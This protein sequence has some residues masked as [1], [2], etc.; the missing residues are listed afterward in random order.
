MHRCGKRKILTEHNWNGQHK[1]SFS[2]FPNKTNSFTCNVSLL[3]IALYHSVL[4][5]NACRAA[6]V[7]CIQSKYAAGGAR[8]VGWAALFVEGEVLRRPFRVCS[9]LS[10]SLLTPGGAPSKLLSYSSRSIQPFF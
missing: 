4:P 5:G 10:T 3:C 8:L 7:I 6:I 1:L 9:I 2:T